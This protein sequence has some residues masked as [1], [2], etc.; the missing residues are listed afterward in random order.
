MTA[1]LNIYQ[2]L[3]KILDGKDYVTISH[4]QY[5]VLLNTAKA[6][7]AVINDNRIYYRDLYYKMTT[8]ICKETNHVKVQLAKVWLIKY[9]S[10][11][12][13]EVTKTE[14]ELIMAHFTIIP[15]RRHNEYKI[16]KRIR[17]C[18]ENLP[19]PKISEPKIVGK[20]NLP[21]RSTRPVKKQ[22]DESTNKGHKWYGFS[23]CYCS[24]KLHDPTS[25]HLIPASKGGNRSQY[26]LK[27]CCSRCNQWR[28]NKDLTEWKNAIAAKEGIYKKENPVELEIIV[29]NIDYLINYIELM[30]AKLYNHNHIR[31]LQLNF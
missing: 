8:F 22:R 12:I 6:D 27:P 30:G 4:S 3:D 5:F 20:I 11:H 10:G 24:K 21:D 2:I 25:E 19:V 17:P 18:V 16:N 28:G 29:S 13:D 15:Y 23:C 26:N 14:R 1:P 7:Q 31:Y 9:D